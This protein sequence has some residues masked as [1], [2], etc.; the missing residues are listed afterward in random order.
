MSTA[1]S[2]SAASWNAQVIQEF[3]AN[4]GKVGGMLDGVPLVLLTTA[5][6]KTGRPHTTPVVHLRDG[7][8]H[9]VFGS[10]AGR[11]DHPD[12][13]RNVLANPQVTMEVG[14]DAPALPDLLL[15][16]A[17]APHP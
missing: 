9:L 8:R 6:R 11:P 1:P 13:Y 7:D 2:G 16:P 3:R 15:R 17:T 5:G 14:T 4:N 12:W 10:N